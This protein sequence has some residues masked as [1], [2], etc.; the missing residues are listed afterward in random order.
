[1]FLI[2]MEVFLC[3]ILKRFRLDFNVHFFCLGCLYIAIEALEHP[4][5]AKLHDESDEPICP[6]PFVVEVDELSL[7][8][9]DMKDIIYE[10][11]MHFNPQL[12]T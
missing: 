10:E 9:K 12:R 5:L 11:S 2:S 6:T 4:Y 1:M 3:G 8:E 7:S